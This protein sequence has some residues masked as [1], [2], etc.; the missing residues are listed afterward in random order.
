MHPDIKKLV[1]AGKLRN[2]AGVKLSALEPGVFVQHKSWGFGRISSWDVT[3]E[4]VTIDFV[5]KKGHFMQF[6][7][8]A[9][10]LS[11]LPAEHF[12][13]R[14]MSDLAGL[15]KMAKEDPRSVVKLILESLGGKATIAQMQQLMSPE[16]TPDEAAFN[17][18]WNAAKKALRDDGH[19]A[20]PAK[21]A[22][23]VV[24]RAE[25]ISRGSALLARWQAA[26]KSKEQIATLD[27]V[28]KNLGE[29]ADAATHLSPLVAGAASAAAKAQRL[30]S[31]AALE[32]FAL[33]EEIA[34]TAKLTAPQPGL[35]AFLRG[36]QTRLSTLL[37]NPNATRLRQVLR[38]FPDAFGDEWATQ[39]AHILPKA[40]GPRLPAEICRALVDLG[41]PDVLKTAFDQ[42]IRSYTVTCE[43][44]H[45][46]ASERATEPARSFLSPE[47]LSTILSALERDTVSD[48]RRGT[49]LRELLM[50]DREL[51]PD[52]VSGV[53][54]DRVRGVARSLL[55]SHAFDELTRKSLMARV[56][57]VH[58]SLS[59]LLDGT[60]HKKEE[61]PLIVS[62]ASMEQRKREY[63]ELVKEKIPQN[64][65]DIAI[66]RSY[67]DL[68]ENFEFKSAKQQQAVLQG[69]KAALEAQLTN[70]RGTNFE[71]ADVTQVSIGTRVKLRATSGEIETLSILGAW[72]T[73]PEAGIMSYLAPSAQSLLGRRV[74]DVVTL[75]TGPH[76][77]VEISAFA[78]PELAAKA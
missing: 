74:G 1:E 5:T 42:A 51:I 64:V 16:I 8:A 57:K 10:T 66:A 13:A 44:L 58:P 76:E 59:V 37:G 3:L 24:Y 4:Q 72:D 63:D 55:V 52:L 39:A 34:D 18:W 62:W 50:N 53:E 33:A 70:C 32:L 31:A 54:T 15:Q 65:K 71:N 36:E 38:R 60:E 6:P 11:P 12:L 26:R 68:R 77:I 14:K 73:D 46:L 45:W 29:F 7:F 47:L 19:F 61:Q 20:I 9:E 27:D 56:I 40:I 69:Q 35:A 67:G 28:L 25:S 41:R 23:P 43:M 75:N 78:N 49:K 22:E 17:K 48:I 2:D 30:D 21:K